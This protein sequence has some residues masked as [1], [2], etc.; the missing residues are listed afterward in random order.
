[1]QF[2]LKEHNWGFSNR[3][4][5]YG[6]YPLVFPAQL[7]ASCAF[8]LCGDPSDFTCSVASQNPKQL[9]SIATSNIKITIKADVF[10]ASFMGQALY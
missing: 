10:R 9:H 5:N 7:G 4:K 1:M 3:L 2:S 8:Q 6:S